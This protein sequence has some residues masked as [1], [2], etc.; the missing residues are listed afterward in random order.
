V[1]R[2]GIGEEELEL[3]RPQLARDQVGLPGQL[4]SQLGILQRGQLD[5]VASAGLELA[6]VLALGPQRGRL[7]GVA[8]GKIGIIPDSRLGEQLL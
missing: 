6:P 2:V 8:S 1:G 5:K 7:L 3:L 4:E